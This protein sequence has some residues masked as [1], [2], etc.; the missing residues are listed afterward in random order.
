MR[1]VVL[2]FTFDVTLSLW[3]DTGLL[4]REA[5]L[6]ARLAEQGWRVTLLTYGGREDVELGRTLAPIET[7]ALY[8]SAA[9]PRSAVVRL[10][11]SPLLV[12]KARH[13]LRTAT[14]L[15]T[16]QIWGGWNAVLAKWLF[17]RPLLARGGYEAYAFAVAQGASFL[18]RMFT[19]AICRLTY[20]TAD[21]ICLTTEQDKTFVMQT[22]GQ[23]SGKIDVRA[24]WVDTDLFR[25]DA[26]HESQ[27]EDRVLF[28]G[29]FHEQK[30]LVALMEAVAETRLSLDLAGWGGQ[31]Q[32][33]RRQAES[34]GARVRFLG[35]VANDALPAL[36]CRYPIFAL[37]SHYEGNPK[38]L[39]EAM[40][41]G[42][43]VLG[44]NVAGIAGLVEHGVSG[45]LCEPT[46]KAIGAGLTRLAG[47]PGLRRRL[48]EQARR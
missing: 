28:V 36:I 48:G 4:S 44:S 29:R 16:N 3:R 46:A 24:N 11:L 38:V 21:R 6:Y 40:A 14:I 30:N 9:R 5:R 31:E 13:L 10:V 42:R 26:A 20:G 32:T 45:L 37:V 1:H 27:Y 8:G 43:A 47:D 41:C 25:P 18:R 15:K 19:K 17:R 23:P 7:F 35:Q 39:L 2:F 33:L 34:I 22:F 12:W